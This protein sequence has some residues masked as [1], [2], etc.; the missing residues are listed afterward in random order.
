[1]E[2][3]TMH[4]SLLQATAFF[5]LAM[6]AGCATTLTPPD[7]PAAIRAPNDQS[8]VLEALATGVQI[9]ECSRRADSTYE[10]SFKAPE[11]LLFTGSGQS[12][13]KHYGGPTWESNDG[14]TVVAAVKTRDPGPDSTAIPWLLL[15]A[16]TNTGSGAFTRIKSIQRVATVGGLAPVEACTANSLKQ[17]ARVPYTATYYFYR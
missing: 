4:Y 16:K 15:N 2:D 1:M 5:G 12:L 14:S 11:A 8:L 17:V 3:F 13:G 10:W 7:V 6:F 9:Y